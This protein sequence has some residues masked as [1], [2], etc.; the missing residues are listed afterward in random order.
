MTNLRIKVV[1]L[2]PNRVR[3]SKGKKGSLGA[4]MKYKFF[5]KLSTPMLSSITSGFKNWQMSSTAAHLPFLQRY[6]S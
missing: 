5:R 4:R 3:K 1:L 2:P 6:K